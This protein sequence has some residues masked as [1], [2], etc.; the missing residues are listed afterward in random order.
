MTEHYWATFG[1]WHCRR[2]LARPEMQPTTPRLTALCKT[3]TARTP[4]PGP[5]P[6]ARGSGAR[7][8]RR[9]IARVAAAASVL[10]G[11]GA[12]PDENINTSATI[13]PSVE[14]LGPITRSRAQQ[15]NHQVKSFLC[16]SAYNIESRL[17][18]NDLIILMNQ[19]EDH[20]GQI[21]HQE[22]AREPG[23]RARECGEPI[24]FRIAQFES[25]SESR[26]TSYSN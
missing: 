7:G 17:L 13:I 11:G 14:I 2:G 1:P 9:E 25:N 20:G 3:P 18:H 22:G 10:V 5:A 8:V 16:S 21:E 26:T 12:P 24:Q 23:R 15:L 6:L 19:G 4:R